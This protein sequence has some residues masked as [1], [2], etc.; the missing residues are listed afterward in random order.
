[1]LRAWDAKDLG[2]FEVKP[3]LQP[4]YVP[5]VDGCVRRLL[6]CEPLRLLL[7]AY[8]YRYQNPTFRTVSIIY[9]FFG[10]LFP[11]YQI[12]KPGWD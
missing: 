3:L 1:M 4:E 9:L 11:G 8:V 7:A 2:R 10:G 6:T 12:Q 5:R